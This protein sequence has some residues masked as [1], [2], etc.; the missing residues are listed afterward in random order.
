M[1]YSELVRIK[2][3]W[4][5]N[6]YSNNDFWVLLKVTDSPVLYNYKNYPEKS[7]FMSPTGPGDNQINSLESI[8]TK[9]GIGLIMFE[10]NEFVY[11]S[12]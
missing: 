5:G 1:K 12:N 3:I 7:Y 10:L 6:N 4:V 9:E 11:K 2:D 8:G